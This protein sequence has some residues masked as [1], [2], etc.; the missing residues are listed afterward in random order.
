M[1]R[2]AFRLACAAGL[3]AALLVS[4]AAAQPMDKRT[5]FTFSGPVAMPG[6]T[7]PGGE[8]IFRLADPDMSSSVV[9]VLGAKN[10]TPYGLF[11]T[12]PAERL[13]AS[14]KP[15]VRFMETAKGMPQAIQTWWYPDETN[16]YEFIYPK[17][18]A[19]LLAEGTG[20]H[21]LTT[22]AETTKTPETNTSALAR[23]SSAGH[24]TKVE[25]SAK[26]MAAEPTGP[27]QEGTIAS[28][29]IAIAKPVIP[30][31]SGTMAKRTMLPETASSLPEIA[32][33]GMIALLGGVGLWGWRTYALSP[34]ARR[35]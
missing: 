32:L 23:V 27:K 29:D 12:I 5:F 10:H 34:S 35:R 1:L 21:V 24:E 28:A 15:E 6:I 4:T 19:R 31:A 7:L 2:N 14:V 3:F 13:H 18:Q 9:E 8:Y 33:V 16:G 30:A 20:N 25:A 17:K 26:P 22:A 11:F